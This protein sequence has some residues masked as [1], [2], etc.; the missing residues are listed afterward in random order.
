MQLLE[1][2]KEIC[3]EAKIYQASSSEMF[4][5]NIDKD[6]FQKIVYYNEPCKPIWLFKSYGI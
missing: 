4:G 5:N 1:L 3:P 2:S 6:G